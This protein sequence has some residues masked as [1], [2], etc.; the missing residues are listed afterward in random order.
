MGNNTI[1]ILQDRT[2]DIT[3]T[4]IVGVTLVEDMVISPK[5]QQTYAEKTYKNTRKEGDQV[6][7]ISKV[8]SKGRPWKTMGQTNKKDLDLNSLYHQT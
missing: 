7:D 5:A 1:R 8:K 4:E 2:R 6:E 3:I